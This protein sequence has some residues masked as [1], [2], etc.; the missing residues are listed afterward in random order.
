[1]REQ[2]VV[3]GELRT[4][5]DRHE[6]E[7]YIQPQVAL[8][9]GGIMGMEAVLR[10]NHPTRGQLHPL[11]FLPIAEKTGTMLAIGRWVLDRSCRQ[12]HLWRKA[13]IAPA[14]I[15][16]SLSL[17]ELKTASE[18]V[19]FVAS[20]LERWDLPPSSLEFG[21]TE[22]ML[23]HTTLANNDVIKR[24]QLSGIKIAI[25]DFGTK[26]S[27]L[28]Y[29]RTFRVNRLKIARAMVDAATHH[30]G[31]AAMVRAIT[32]IA[33]ELNV[34]VVVQGVEL[35]AQWA[36]LNAVTPA[37]NVQ[38]YFYGEPVPEA[39]ATLLLHE[40]VVRPAV[41]PAAVPV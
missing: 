8:A 40:G 21:V 18:F 6:F 32:S 31:N 3:A 30:S 41:H 12:M 17:A 39:R 13:G 27:S 19:Q 2:V 4:G 34:E 33:R 24:L 20:T 25:D 23:A 16:V 9:S 15:A 35:E 1:M 11:V 28:D 26:F 14:T 38:G 5:L 29:L 22:S 10:W 36:F 37:T 7:L